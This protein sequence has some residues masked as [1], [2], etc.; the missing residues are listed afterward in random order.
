[1]GGMTMIEIL[2]VMA[3]IAILIGII[4]AGLSYSLRSANA[5]QTKAILADLSAMVAE[6]ELIKPLPD[7]LQEPTLNARTDLEPYG[8]S[9]TVNNNTYTYVPQYLE[10]DTV[11]GDSRG[12]QP[13]DVAL[14]SGSLGLSGS[15]SY[16]I[17]TNIN[18]GGPTVP[19]G[20]A[21]PAEA[22]TAYVLS[23]LSA[24]PK[25]Q[26]LLSKIPGTR[27][28][29]VTITTPKVITTW[30]ENPPGS[31]SFTEGYWPPQTAKLPLILP[32]PLDA[33]G[34]EIYFVPGG[35]LV[36]STAA[37][38]G[39]PLAT[40]TSSTGNGLWSSV[41][42]PSTGTYSIGQNSVTSP[43]GKAFWVSAGP[44][45]DMLMGDDNI[46]SFTP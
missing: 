5:S 43:T 21:S 35:G 29:Q 1:M 31:G 38:A 42:N 24:L 34:H 23:K 14:G 17:T 7:F 46:Y 13:L 36:N 32:V 22:Y 41:V 3:I 16:T 40:P 12:H 15:T 27:F 25:N 9:V 18:N 19:A 2:V 4:F 28:T 37:S 20:S 6:A 33:W 39:I 11:P 10:V 8:K 45:G 26:E 30:Y 44:D